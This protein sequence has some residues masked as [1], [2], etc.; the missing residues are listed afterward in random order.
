ML[1]KQSLTPPRREP[2]MQVHSLL[3]LNWIL[4]ITKSLHKQPLMTLQETLLKKKQMKLNSSSLN[5][6]RKEPPQKRKPLDNKNLTQTTKF[7]LILLMKLL[8]R[9]MPPML[10]SLI[11][12]MLKKHSTL[13]L[14]P[15][16]YKQRSNTPLL[17]L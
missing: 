4:P 14:K 13:P 12:S 6:L 16:G 1:N 2:Q 11:L 17:M 15:D 10:L 9:R 3:V 8:L 7:S 5:T